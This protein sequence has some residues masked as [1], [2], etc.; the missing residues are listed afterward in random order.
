MVEVLNKRWAGPI[1]YCLGVLGVISFIALLAPVVLIHTIVLAR[2]HLEASL[3]S[4]LSLI[5]RRQ[6]DAALSLP[7]SPNQAAPLVPTEVPREPLG[8]YAAK[9][10]V[11]EEQ[12]PRRPPAVAAFELESEPS[13]IA[14]GWKK[15]R[16]AHAESGSR[17]MSARDIFN[18]SFGV[19]TA[20]AN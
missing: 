15:L 14:T 5:Q 2:P 18:R 16:V 1:I 3:P 9:L 11:A 19:L 7:A 8:L 6:M 13:S 20:A 10:D 12:E 17:D 4:P